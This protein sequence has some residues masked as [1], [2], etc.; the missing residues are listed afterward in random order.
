M[1][2]LKI[3]PKHHHVSLWKF[4][5]LLYCGV[6]LLL[7]ASTIHPECFPPEFMKKFKIQKPE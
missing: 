5:Y 1:G 6:G 3:I 7:F 2:I 4:K